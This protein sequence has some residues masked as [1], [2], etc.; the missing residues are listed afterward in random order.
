MASQKEEVIVNEEGYSAMSEEEEG[1]RQKQAISLGRLLLIMSCLV[2][3]GCF[4]FLLL[5]VRNRLVSS[6]PAPQTAVHQCW[7]ARARATSTATT[8]LVMGVVT[9]ITPPSPLPGR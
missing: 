9:I 3:L 6:S 2:V 1:K 8:S 4:N 7:S 5:K